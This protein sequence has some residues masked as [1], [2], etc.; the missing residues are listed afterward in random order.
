LYAIMYRYAY[1]YTGRMG[2]DEY[3]AVELSVADLRKNIAAAIAAAT[4]DGRLTFITAAV[5]GSPSSARSAWF[6]PRLGRW[7][8]S[9]R[10]CTGTVTTPPPHTPAVRCAGRGLG[11]EQP[12]QLARILAISG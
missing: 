12:G 2:S 5:A 6:R 4:D 1:S 3:A 9:S 8:T 10:S 7:P 11:S